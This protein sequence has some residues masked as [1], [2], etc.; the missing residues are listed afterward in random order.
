MISTINHSI[1]RILIDGKY[2]YFDPSF[3][4][5]NRDKYYFMTFEEASSYLDLS[6]YEE[7]KMKVGRVD[8]QRQLHF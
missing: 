6:L 1:V 7:E 4:L 5:R 3:D 2:Y 8:E